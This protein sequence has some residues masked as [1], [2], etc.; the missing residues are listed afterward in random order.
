MTCS[1]LPTYLQILT[2]YIGWFY[3][4]QFISGYAEMSLILTLTNYVKIIVGK[5]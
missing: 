3:P 2:K 1:L 5:Y 4:N